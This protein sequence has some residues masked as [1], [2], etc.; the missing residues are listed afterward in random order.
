MLAASMQQASESRRLL[1]GGAEQIGFR[2][3]GPQ[4]NMISGLL[5]EGHS[6]SR[7]T[8]GLFALFQQ[9]NNSIDLPFPGGALLG[10]LETTANPL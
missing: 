7:Q 9:E 2:R 1:K 8:F 4:T 5:G 6:R 3:L 10:S